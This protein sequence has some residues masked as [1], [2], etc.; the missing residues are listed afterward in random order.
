MKADIYPQW[1]NLAN[2]YWDTPEGQVVHDSGQSI[3]DMLQNDYGAFR[4]FSIGSLDR[5]NGMWMRF[6]DEQAYT[7][8]LLRWS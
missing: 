6:P 3:W 7:M 8:F 5:D 2:W 4:T 1:M